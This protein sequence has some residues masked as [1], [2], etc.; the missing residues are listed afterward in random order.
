MDVKELRRKRAG[1]VIEAR[2]L[3]DL[4][5]TEKRELTAEETGSYD[6]IMADVGTMRAKIDQE[7]KLADAERS[8]EGIDDRQPAVKPD[9][10]GR[11]ADGKGE[12]EMRAKALRGFFRGGLPVLSSDERRALEAG[13]DPAG[14]YIVTPQQ[15][16]TTLIKAVDDA[17]Q[18]RSLATVYPLAN[19]ESLG[20]PT[21]DADPADADWTTELATGSE[22]STMSFGKR[23]LKPHPMAKR[24]KIS[25]RL[26]N[27]AA[28]PVENIVRD[29][30]AYKVGITQEKAFM[31]GTG[32][33]QPLGL[34]TASADGITTA[35]DVSTG[36]T[37]TSIQADGLIEA[38]FKVK[39]AYHPKATWLFHPDAVKQ[40]TKLKDGDG[41][42]IWQPGLQNAQPDV[43]LGR[44]YVMSEYAPNTFTTGLYVGLF[45]DFSNYWIVDA[46][47]MQIQRLIELYAEANQVGFIARY[48]GDGMPV[49]AE[50]F[51]RV[52][53]A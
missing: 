38:K 16:M 42:Y 44:P 26:L 51:A 14:G 30:I 10:E 19:A 2:K 32:V 13:S 12:V 41:A 22:D 21:L 37:A 28:L 31:T 50:A 5:E 43:I 47:N 18:V 6:K 9:P 23:E 39:A 3:L 40:I 45:G 20:V 35:R 36:N 8:I 29:R 17:V 24:I 46:L 48:E 7:E 49:L 27:V 11:D 33:S 4:A 25:N 53:L 34:F 15:F 1:L 52:K